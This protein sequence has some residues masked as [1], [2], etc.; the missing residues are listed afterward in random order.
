MQTTLAAIPSWVAAP[1]RPA[2][3]PCE[4]AWFPLARS[5]A[6]LPF[7]FVQLMGRF[8]LIPSFW[9]WIPFAGAFVT[10]AFLKA[11]LDDFFHSS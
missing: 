5:L 9:A 4:A 11:L 7:A 6:L 1:P 10:L 2:D 8:C 3:L